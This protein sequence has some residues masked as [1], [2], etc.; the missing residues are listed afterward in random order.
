ME[1]ILTSVEAPGFSLGQ[2]DFVL[3]FSHCWKRV[4]EP[5]NKLVFIVNVRLIQLRTS[6]EQDGVSGREHAYSYAVLLSCELNQ[7]LPSHL[8]FFTLLLEFV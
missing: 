1:I 2:L 4:L 7:I 5:V 8:G 3:Y 6:A